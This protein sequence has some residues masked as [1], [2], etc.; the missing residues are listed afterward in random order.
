MEPVE[1]CGSLE[2]ARNK[3]IAW[4]ESKGVVFGPHHKIEIGRLGDL[5]GSETGV[6][7]T[8]PPFWRL[9]LDYDPSKGPHYNVEYGSGPGRLKHAFTFPGTPALIARLATTQRPR[10]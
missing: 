4:L 6:S 5:K 3:A 8:I 7:S 2:Q 1:K 9:R 10:G